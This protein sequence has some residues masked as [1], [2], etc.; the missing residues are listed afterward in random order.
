MM[1]CTWLFLI[2]EIWINTCFQTFVQ[3]KKT[4]FD[5]VIPYTVI[6]WNRD[7]FWD[8][9]HTVKISYRYNPSR[10]LHTQ[11]CALAPLTEPAVSLSD[12]VNTN[13]ESLTERTINNHFIILFEKTTVKYTDTQSSS[14]Q[15][16]KI[17][18]CF[19]TR[20]NW[21]KLRLYYNVAY[22]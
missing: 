3:P 1:K 11:V 21:Q 13:T 5:C 6:S 20:R 8:D 18:V 14:L 15:P 7:I 16:V 17:K 10:V 9:Y 12:D 22:F 4:C 19:L 2:N